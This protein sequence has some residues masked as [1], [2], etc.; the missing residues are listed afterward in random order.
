MFTGYAESEA[1]RGSVKGKDRYPLVDFGLSRVSGLGM[2]DRSKT[3]G[4][5]FFGGCRRSGFACPGIADVL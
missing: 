4:S 1:W 2:M 3:M 5:G